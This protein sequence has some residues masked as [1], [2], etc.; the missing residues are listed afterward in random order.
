MIKTYETMSAKKAAPIITQLNDKEAMTI[1]ANI[2]SDTLAAI[3][4][5]MNAVDAAKYTSLL[6]DTSS[7]D[8]E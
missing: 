1:L 4:E 5:Q 3:M 7:L 2:K 6:T 8:Q